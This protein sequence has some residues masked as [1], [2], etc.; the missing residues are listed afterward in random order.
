[1]T[2]RISSHGTAM[3][4]ASQLARLQQGLASSLSRMGSGLQ[5]EKAADDPAGLTLSNHL[6]SQARG[7]GQAMRNASDAVSLAQVAEGGLAGIGATLHGIR[8]KVLQAGSAG[9]SPESRVAIQSDIRAAVRAVDDIAANTRFTNQPLLSGAFTDQAFQVGIRPGETVRFSIGAVNSENLGHPDLGFLADIDVRSAE[10]TEKAI[11]VVE[12]A[13]GQVN[14]SRASLGSTYRQLESSVRSTAAARVQ[15]MA[16]ASSMRDVDF[17]AESMNMNRMK[18]LMHASLFAQ[19]QG[20]AN[21]ENVLSLL[22][23]GVG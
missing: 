9:Q 2:L 5:I 3:S 13:M 1:M 6:F 17:A 21:R 10:G 7:F 20:G 8:E 15:S 14:D 16:S 18:N 19:V 4:G 12:A 22:M 11:A 23:P